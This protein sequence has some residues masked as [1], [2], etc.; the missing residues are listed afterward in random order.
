MLEQSF[1]LG[2]VGRSMVSRV[3]RVNYENWEKLSVMGGVVH[4]PEVGLGCNNS[5]LNK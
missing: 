2:W 4:Q 5:T 3:S 1:I